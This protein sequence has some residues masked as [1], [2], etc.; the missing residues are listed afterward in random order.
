M[1]S[2]ISVCAS[3]G[4]SGSTCRGHSNVASSSHDSSSDPASLLLNPRV[5]LVSTG[6]LPLRTSNNSH[7]F[8]PGLSLGRSVVFSLWVMNDLSL[9]GDVLNSFVYFFDGFLHHD[10]FFDFSADIFDL[11]LDC[12][13]VGDCS[14]HRDPLIPDDFFI[15]N[16][17]CFVG[18]LINLLH[19][20]ILNVFLF[21]GHVLNSAF[22]GN[23]RSH[24]SLSAYCG[25][26]GSIL[27]HSHV[28]IVGAAGGS[29]R[30]S[31]DLIRGSIGIVNAASLLDVG[32]LTL[33][34]QSL[35]SGVV[36]QIA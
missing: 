33:L 1:S 19:L 29:P 30:L 35:A 22:H 13:V 12:I 10:C 15:L 6:D 34:T 14:L 11:G 21:E 4:I 5:G 26:V 3:V 25:R 20:F 23:I 17:F 9:D 36:G 24:L 7:I 2:R 27:R 28:L 18:N 32:R 8:S 16:D 31:I